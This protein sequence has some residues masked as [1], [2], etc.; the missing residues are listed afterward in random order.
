M[1]DTILARWPLAL[2]TYEAEVERDCVPIDAAPFQIGESV[3]DPGRLH[4]GPATVMSMEMSAQ[5]HWIAGISWPQGGFT[6]CPA[7]MLRR[8]PEGFTA[9]PQPPVGSVRAGLSEQADRIARARDDADPEHRLRWARWPDDYAAWEARWGRDA[10][11]NL[12]VQL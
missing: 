10:E 11:W 4:L 2:E 8:A 9:A 7:K 12:K 6:L 3:I 5:G 1:P